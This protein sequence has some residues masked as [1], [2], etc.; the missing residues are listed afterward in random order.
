MSDYDPAK[1]LADARAREKERHRA[2][3]SQAR[4]LAEA[5]YKEA[6]ERGLPPG[7]SIG[8]GEQAAY[9]FL[10]DK[11]GRTAALRLSRVIGRRLRKK[12]GL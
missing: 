9:S 12:A 10:S 3:S 1:I 8:V 4:E 6:R 7:N 11:R 5:A 2:F